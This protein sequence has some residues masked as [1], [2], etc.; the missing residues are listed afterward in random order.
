MI[1]LKLFDRAKQLIESSQKIIL[2]THRKP[3]GDACGSVAAL[4]QALGRCGKE[5]SVL[6]LSEL[7]EWYEFVFSTRPSELD[8]DIRIA[9]IESNRPDLVIICDTNSHSQLP[10]IGK[11]LEPNDVS[12]LVFDHHAT[13]D[14]L[15]DV[16]LVDSIASATAVI[17]YE[18]LRYA[19]WE[20]DALSAQALF[21]GIAMD[22]GW[23]SFSN[24]DSRSMRICADLIE[25]GAV[26]TQ[27]YKNLNKNFSLERFRLMV[28]ML[29]RVE[30]H[31]D[32]RLATQYLLNDDF[33]KTGAKYSDTEDFVNLCQRINS[34][35][36]AV[37]FVELPD[38]SIRC[39]LRSS[40]KLDVR[41][42]A[43]KHEGG[44]HTMAAGVQLDG[45]FANARNVL[46]K[47]IG[48]AFA[49]IDTGSQ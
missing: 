32:G 35:E 6:L 12:V 1:D 25:T 38:G 31:F 16:E 47:E 42:V 36:A 14:G 45:P 19:R 24:T 48:D 23:Y 30:L 5:V 27:I 49:A 7:P 15:G 13:S 39:S 8:K 29:Q 9:D 41:A 40:G 46:L 26:P 11:W 18:F 20:I 34:V 33:K 21:V 17:V 28:V 22:T 10:I 43:Q 4:A 2:T 37:L 3:D 44:G